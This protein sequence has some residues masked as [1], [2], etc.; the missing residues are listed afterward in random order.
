MK[1][2]FVGLG[3]MG[4]P[5]VRR[6]SAAGHSV[7]VWARRPEALAPVAVL[8]GVEVFDS[9]A[10]LAGKCEITLS[11]VTRDADVESVL[12]GSQGLI[13]GW[14]P[15]A[16]HIDMSTIAPDS[17]RRFAEVLATQQVR[18]LDAPVSGGPVGAAAGSLS[19]MMGGAAD[20]IEQARPV[21]EIL[22]QRLVHVG[23]NGAGQ[24][25]KAC[26]QMVMVAS[27]QAVAEAFSLASRAGLDLSR[28]RSALQGG[29]GASRVLDVFGQRMIDK[30]YANGVE[31]RLHHKDFAIVLAAAQGMSL[32][33]PLTGLVWERLNAL[34][35]LGG[36]Y[37]DTA[38]LFRLFERV[39]IGDGET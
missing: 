13:H 28:V 15:G 29:F 31:S 2:G 11:I 37:D 4:V 16:L 9:P 1:L 36:A 32:G 24:V 14:R 27:I 34:Q 5:M 8:P 21:L 25:A 38:S 33:L 22:G 12:L 10:S 35:A 20:D 18:F 39:E 23:P 19:I 30:A 6:L 26:N 17:A 3:T 7:G